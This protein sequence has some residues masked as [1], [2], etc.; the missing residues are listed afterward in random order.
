MPLRKTGASSEVLKVTD[1]RGRVPYDIA[2]LEVLGKRQTGNFLPTIH[3]AYA[4][5]LEFAR[6]MRRHSSCGIS[7]GCRE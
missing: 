3:A 6:A 1:S 5:S 7:N 4:P 2:T